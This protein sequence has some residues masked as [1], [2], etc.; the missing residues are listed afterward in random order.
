MIVKGAIFLLMNVEIQAKTDFFLSVVNISSP[1][2]KPLVRVVVSEGEGL[3]VR[4]RKETHFSCCT[5]RFF[6]CFSCA[7][8]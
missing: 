7:C 4:C 2:Y 3:G 5:L 6:Q 8:V 1:L